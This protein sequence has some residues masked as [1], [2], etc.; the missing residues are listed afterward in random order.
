[1]NIA[2]QIHDAALEHAHADVSSWDHDG[3]SWKCFEKTMQWNGLEVTFE[4]DAREISPIF[5][6]DQLQPSDP[7]EYDVDN[8][9]VMRVEINYN[10]IKS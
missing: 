8:L 6:G 2:Q 9:V 10:I 4:C 3:E 7:Y 5:R 1:M